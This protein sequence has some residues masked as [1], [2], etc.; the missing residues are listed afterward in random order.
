MNSISIQ[1]SEV[2]K[3]LIEKNAAYLIG[4]LRDGYVDEKQYLISIYQKDKVWLEYLKNLVKETFGVD[5]KIRPFR[6]A[7]ELR[8]F[9]KDLFNYIRK[10]GVANS[11]TTPKK[12]L[13]TKELW[14]PYISGFFDAEGHC[15]SPAT[16]RKTGKKKVSMH[17]NDRN[18]LEFIKSV[19]E[20]SGIKTSKIYLQKG[21]ECHALYIQSKEGIRKFAVI[22][23]PIRKR[24]QLDDLLSVMPP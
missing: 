3:G 2:E 22:V 10:M 6:D 15:T 9:S 4:A 1:N 5:S 11:S 16:F 8:I 21:R 14:I 19:L 24:K 20:E 18:S 7:F 12:V 23:N 13:D 17:Q